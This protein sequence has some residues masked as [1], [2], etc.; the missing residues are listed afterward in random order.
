MPGTERDISSRLKVYR[1]VK[2]GIISRELPPGAMIH[3]R[4]LA[5][6][7]GVSRSPV[8]EALQSLQDDGW[9]TVMPRKGSVVRPL[10]RVEIE[11]VLQLR[12]IIGAAG[13]QLS[14]GRVSAGALAHLKGII[15][16]QEI[17]SQVAD[18]TRFIDA[19]MQLH[20][21]LV[22]LAGNSR[23]SRMAED[24][25]DNFRRVALE[26]VAGRGDLASPLAEHRAI[27]EA[28]ERDDRLTAEKILIE[29]IES[30]RQSLV[31]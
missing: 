14:A 15:A 16:R 24:L 1:Y 26:A 11:E 25:L 8:R 18:Y 12:I 28:L 19:D 10:S 6:I 17:A 31:A 22:Q 21:A 23:L 20:I 29:H 27:V 30:A 7:I 5:Q 4:D 2:D 13:I 9:L 3:E